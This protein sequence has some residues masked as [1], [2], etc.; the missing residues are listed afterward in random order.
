MA[1]HASIN[2]ASKQAMRVVETTAVRAPTVARDHR[3]EPCGRVRLGAWLRSSMHCRVASH[4]LAQDKRADMRKHDKRVTLNRAQLP[5]DALTCA[6]RPPHTYT[7][8]SVVRIAPTTWNQ[9]EN[10]GHGRCCSWATKMQCN[11]HRQ[12]RIAHAPCPTSMISAMLQIANDNP[13]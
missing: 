11:T 3:G 4:E 1:R 6:Q 10:V 2:H 13:M 5:N 9:L 7:T 8:H 12:S